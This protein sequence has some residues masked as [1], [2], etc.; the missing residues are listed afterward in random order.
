LLSAS[1]LVFRLFFCFSFPLVLLS[2]AANLFSCACWCRIY[3]GD[4][5]VVLAPRSW[6]GG[7]GFVAADLVLTGDGFVV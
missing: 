4:R 6:C 1:G 3:G 5:F 7:D 2:L